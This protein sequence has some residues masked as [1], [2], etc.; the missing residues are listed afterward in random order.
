MLYMPA[1]AAYCVLNEQFVLHYLSLRN[2]VSYGPDILSP[3]VPDID[4][5]KTGPE[6][7][8]VPGSANHT[9]S[10]SS[11]ELNIPRLGIAEI[12]QAVSPNEP[13]T[14]RAEV[15]NS[16]PSLQRSTSS[17]AVPLPSMLSRRGVSNRR[18]LHLNL[19]RSSPP[20]PH[21]NSAT[22][23]YSYTAIGH[24]PTSPPPIIG[25]SPQ[26]S[27]FSG[28]LLH[29]Q[30]TSPGVTTAPLLYSYVPSPVSGVPDSSGFFRVIPSG[31]TAAHHQ[32]VMARGGGVIFIP[33][34]S[35]RRRESIENEA[36]RIRILESSRGDPLSVRVAS[37]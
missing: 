3:S 27:M 20:L 35:K 8:F 24:T 14:A 17:N 25:G 32:A 31:A 15:R 33:S 22:P 21:Q 12:N 1:M 23:T 34:G 18:N 36:D 37:S 30:P 29:P 7:M 26:P 4:F 28:Q 13:E 10:L 2:S 19:R 6:D 11:S 16:E 9:T 5:N